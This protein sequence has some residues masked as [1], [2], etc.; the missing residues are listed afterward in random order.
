MQSDLL[1][2]FKLPSVP[3]AL[4][5]AGTTIVPPINAFP[6][7]MTYKRAVLLR[8]Y[9]NVVSFFKAIDVPI[10]SGIVAANTLTQTITSNSLAMGVMV[11]LDAGDQTPN[12]VATVVVTYKDLLGQVITQTYTWRIIA[13][14]STLT[15]LFA[16]YNANIVTPL[17]VNLA[18]VLTLVWTAPTGFSIATEALTSCHPQVINLLNDNLDAR[19]VRVD[20]AAPA[21]K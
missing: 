9:A 13:K 16:T 12:G 19:L 4:S 5:L 10:T 11:A 20:Q 21:S 2:H 15:I 3:V 14:N 8:L 18:T 6:S 1:S 17:V 7:Q